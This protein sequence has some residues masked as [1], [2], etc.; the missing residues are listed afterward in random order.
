MRDEALIAVGQGCPLKYLNVSGC[1][2]I[3]DAGI[4][5]VARGCP[6]LTYLDVSVLQVR[7]PFPF[8][9]CFFM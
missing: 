2:Q 7:P 3:G 1:N 6:N 8:P 9:L 4:V 5:A